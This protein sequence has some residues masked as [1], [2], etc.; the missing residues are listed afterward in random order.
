VCFGDT[1]FED[2]RACKGFWQASWITA[3]NYNNDDHK[4]SLFHK[5]KYE[6]DCE[7]LACNGSYKNVVDGGG[8]GGDDDDDR[9][10]STK[11]LHFSNVSSGCAAGNDPDVPLC[12]SCKKTF[13]RS[14]QKCTECDFGY[15]WTKVTLVLVIPLSAVSVVHSVREKMRRS[16][17]RYRHFWGI[18][19]RILSIQVSF[20]QIN[21]SLPHTLP[22]IP[23]PKHFLNWLEFWDFINFDIKFLGMSCVTVGFTFYHSLLFTFTMPLFIVGIG[24]VGYLL[25]RHRVMD[26]SNFT[27][28]ERKK[29]EEDALHLLFKI[30]D[31]DNSGYV[32]PKELCKILENLGWDGIPIE[33]GLYVMA[34]LNTD[35][36]DETRTHTAKGGICMYEEAF[37]TAMTTGKMNKILSKQNI[38]RQQESVLKSGPSRKLSNSFSFYGKPQGSSSSSSSSSSS[39]DDL[40]SHKKSKGKGLARKV[41]LSSSNKLVAWT[42]QRHVLATALAAVTQLLLLVHTPVARKVFQYFGGCAEIA[43]RSYLAVDPQIECG[44]TNYNIFAIF[45]G[46]VLMV[47]VLGLPLFITLYLHR[48]RN[49]LYSTEVYQIVGWLYN[50][51]KHGAELWESWQVV[52]MMLI[53]GGL[54]FIPEPV[55]AGVGVLFTVVY[56]AML[57]YYKPH[58]EVLLFWLSQISLA[59]SCGKYLI[60]LVMAGYQNG[61]MVTRMEQDRRDVAMGSFL[62]ATDVTMLLISASSIGIAFY[63]VYSEALAVKGKTG[64]RWK[65]GV[66]GIGNK[67]R[68]LGK[69]KKK[70]HHAAIEAFVGSSEKKNDGEDCAAASVVQAGRTRSNKMLAQLLG[71]QHGRK[72]QAQVVPVGG[73]GGGG[74]ISYGSGEEEDDEKTVENIFDEYSRSE[75]KFARRKTQEYEAHKIK[76]QQRLAARRKI[77]Q[78]KAL[79]KVPVFAGLDAAA[80]EEILAAMTFSSYEKDHVICKEGE[81]ADRFYVIVSGNC[82]V[83]QAVLSQTSGPG[84]AMAELLALRVGELKAL[85]VMGENALFPTVDGGVGRRSATVTAESA[86]Q[87]MELSH[88]AFEELV[89]SGVIDKDTVKRIG[90]LQEERS[91]ANSEVCASVSRRGTSEHQEA[92][93][94]TSVAALQRQESQR[95]HEMV[96]MKQIRDLQIKILD[97]SVKSEHA[98]LQRTLF[99]KRKRLAKMREEGNGG[100]GVHGGASIEKRDTA[101]SL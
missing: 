28:A 82:G 56:I 60:A 58:K 91:A 33:K 38:S 87:T 65:F 80:T 73:S 29:Q 53:T 23:W 97:P 30:S 89:D 37:V 76:V 10:V 94:P 74:G 81:E 67:F 59:I 64:S 36:A 90:R 4:T 70:A 49:V 51:Y 34:E 13:Y 16:W 31:S 40:P 68:G 50:S 92:K 77:R 61:G 85:D 17:R 20:A 88:T 66:R 48:K 24:Y 32:E 39:T 93:N 26:E 7:G 43:G 35:E 1:T 8:G 9:A 19:F 18:F 52:F 78:A 86:V 101:V 79:T 27:S 71:M 2:I 6:D 3:E 12:Q 55:R 25:E 11:H 83:S 98:E 45:V 62:I 100:G 72:R 84:K 69:A 22:F 42:L 63:L 41:T 5:C 75:E 95:S 21:S 46:I 14:S 44:S 96:L 47:F 54:L 57:N 99:E 15:F